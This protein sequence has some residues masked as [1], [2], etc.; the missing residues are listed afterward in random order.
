MFQELVEWVV[1]L[2]LSIIPQSRDFCIS[3]LHPSSGK[4]FFEVSIQGL[5]LY[6]T[7]LFENLIVIC[8]TFI[9][10]DRLFFMNLKLEILPLVCFLLECYFNSCL[11]I[12]LYK[13]PI[14]H[15]LHI[16][17]SERASLPQ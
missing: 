4:L 12:Q 13:A 10:L 14:H 1:G 3:A 6:I 16:A 15:F 9:P 2:K 17:V 11:K 5:Y 7:L 8:S